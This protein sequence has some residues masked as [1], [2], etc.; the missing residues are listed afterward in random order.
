MC[1]IVSPL[2]VLTYLIFTANPVIISVLEIRK[3]EGNGAA[4]FFWVASLSFNPES[5]DS[6]LMLLITELY[7]KNMLTH[8][9]VVSL[10]LFWNRYEKIVFILWQCGEVLLYVAF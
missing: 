10:D 9:Y 8:I 7:K 4:G 5:L 1:Q 6:K 3:A 2:H